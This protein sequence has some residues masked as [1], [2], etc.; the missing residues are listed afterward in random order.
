MNKIHVVY[1]IETSRRQLERYLFCF[2]KDAAGDFRPSQR[3]KYSQEEML[4]PGV[5]EEWSLKDLLC[6][7]IEWDRRLVRWCHEALDGLPSAVPEVNPAWENLQTGD[8][9]IPADLQALPIEDVLEEFPHA[10]R[11]VLAAVEALPPD[12]LVAS[13]FFKRAPGSTLADLALAVTAEHYSWAKGRIRRW[14]K[15]HAGAYLNREVILE[16]IRTERR[17]LEQNLAQVPSGEMETAGVVGEWSVK[18]VLAHLVD[19]EQRFLGWYEAGR[20]GE[21]PAVPAPGIGW[22][23]LDLLNRQIYQRNRGRPLE[24]VLTDFHASYARV[25]AVIRDIPEDEIFTPG[26]YSWLGENAMVGPILAN[27]ANHYRWAKGHI[28]AWRLEHHGDQE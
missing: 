11:A 14:R 1:A 6:H 13:G 12:R 5:V 16:R 4:R 3:P 21:R 28:R 17:R 10:Y 25:F 20:R 26:R 2:E 19:W 24:E 8:H 23:E 7:L 27:T 9:E 22:D 18:D 15:T